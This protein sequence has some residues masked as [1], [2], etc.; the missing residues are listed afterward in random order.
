MHTPPSKV[1]TLSLFGAAFLLLFVGSGR[2]GGGGSPPG[3]VNAYRT[4]SLTPFGSFF[5]RKRRGEPEDESKLF[6]F[7]Q[8]CNFAQFTCFLSRV[9]RKQPPCVS[10][11]NHRSQSSLF[12]AL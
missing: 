8:V 11:R 4:T 6:F 7:R 2:E 12:P 5:E 10:F 9:P 1:N 3:C